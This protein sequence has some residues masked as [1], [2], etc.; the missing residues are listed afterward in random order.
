MHIKIANPNSFIVS[1]LDQLP[2]SKFCV[3]T[4]KVVQFDY[5]CIL[6]FSYTSR[7]TIKGESKYLTQTIN[8]FT[9]KLNNNFHPIYMQ[10]VMITM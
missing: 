5:Y 8:L 1:N 6:I 7:M 3:S 4:L 2:K 10:G 9:M